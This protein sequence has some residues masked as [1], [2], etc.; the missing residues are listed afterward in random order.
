VAESAAA[1]PEGRRNGLQSRLEAFSF[2]RH[3]ALWIAAIDVLLILIFGFASTGHVF[4]NG[5]NFINMALDSSQIALIAAGSA[6]LLGAGE[7]DISVGANVILSSVV[8]GK[9]ILA[10]AHQ[11]SSG[12]YTNVG[13]AFAAGIAAAML[14]GVTFGLVNGLIVTAMGVN[15]FVATLGTM[16]IGTGTAL[17]LTNGFDVQGIPYQLQEKFGVK[18]VW[19]IPLP[20]AVSMV[21]I[22]IVWWLLAKTRFGLR[23]LAIGSSRDAAERAGLR[24]SW[25]LVVLFVLLGAFAAV[26][27]VIDIARFTTTNVGGHLN[28]ALAAVAGAVIGGTALFGG[29]ASI[30]GAVLG[31]Y[32][33]IILQTGLVIMGLPAFYQPI[34]IG[35]ILIIAVFVNPPGRTGGGKRFGHHS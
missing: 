7:F 6:M 19:G 1:V 33:S 14:T 34:A 17:V 15:S 9:V 29:R 28:D 21:L 20:L 30:P 27:G 32:L 12:H 10:L 16:G 22:V 35:A 25:H 8:G 3:P 18:T 31:A 5:Q 4:F 2:G 13:V 26:A 24:I 11:T 23:T